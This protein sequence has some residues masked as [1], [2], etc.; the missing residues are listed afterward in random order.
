MSTL[1]SVCNTGWLHKSVVFTLLRLLKYDVQI[2]LPTH[3]P[4]ENN[5]HH[6]VVD[7]LE[8]KHEWWLNVDSDNPPT[9]NPL[10]MLELN[11]DIVGLPTPVWHYKGEKGERPI[12]WNVYESKGE[13]YTEWMPREG[14]Q[15]V[16]AIGT[17]CFLAHRRVFEHPDMKACFQRT[18]DIEGRVDK[19]ND[20]AF[21]ERAR[22]AG[23]S[24]WAHFDYPCDHYN[25]LPLNEVLRA[26]KG[27][28]VQ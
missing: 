5:L 12:Y 7:F 25:E 21:S 2:I 22:A 4:Y 19:G 13:A 26:F 8:S 20:I 17:G 15:K 1:V 27:L 24:I 3:N 9:N 6:V 28:G 23:F 11:L 10:G 14:L 18:Y 16:D